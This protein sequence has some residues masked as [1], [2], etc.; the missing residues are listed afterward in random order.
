[1]FNDA[2]SY[3]GCTTKSDHRVVVARV[4]YGR[5]NLAYSKITKPYK[6]FDCA[7]LTSNTETQALYKIAVHDKLVEM[8]PVTNAN[9]EMNNMF[10]TIKG[11][12]EDTVGF[13][14]GSRVHNFYNDPLVVGL[15]DERKK[16]RLLLH[17]SNQSNDRSDLRKRINHFQTQIKRRLKE[18]NNN[19]AES[20]ANQINNTD[21]SRRMFE[22]V[23]SLAQVKKPKPIYVCDSDGNMVAN[24]IGKAKVL[25]DYFEDKFTSG[26]TT[27]LEC[28]DG[29]PRPLVVPVTPLEVENAAKCLK[30]GRAT[31]P[32]GIPS[33]FIKYS[34]PI[35]YSRYADCI[36]NSLSTNTKIDALGEGMINPLQ[37]PKKYLGPLKNIRPLTLSNSARK[38]LSMVT[39]RR[40][41]DKVN[42]YTGSC[43]SGYKVGRSCADI[44]WSQRML[45]AVVMRKEWQY[46]KLGIDMSSAFDTIKRDVVL[47]VLADAGCTEDELRLVRMLL[48]NTKLKINVNGTIS[49]EF[50]STIGA[51]QGDCLSGD[52]FTITLAAALHHLRA[53][54]SQVAVSPY[55]VTIP[56]P[57]PPISAQFM[58]LETEYADD[59]DFSNEK[60][61]PLDQLYPICKQVFSEWNLTVNDDKT[62]H[63]H[64]YLATPKPQNKKKMV[65]GVEYRG[66]EE[67]R[68]HKVLGS[69]L[70]S[71]EDI[72]KKCILGNAAYANFKKLWSRKEIS[73][74]RKLNIYEAQVVSIMLYNCNS[75][76]APAHVLEHLDVTH[77]NHLRDMLGI[78]WPR[79]YISNNQLYKRCDTRPL[80]ERVHSSRWKMLGHI[81]R[82]E[83]DAPALLALKFSVFAEENKHLFKGRLGAPCMNLLNVFRIDLKKRKI[84]N[85]LKS[86]S[87]LYNLRELAMDRKAWKRYII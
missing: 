17:S 70:C 69:I 48:S 62:E 63:F 3:S 25:K 32:D 86:I 36:N 44:V 20:L 74:N 39:L 76:A 66:H 78:K 46:F 61:E 21:S 42:V 2:R 68:N 67:W 71:V 29:P 49:L 31:G 52:L 10:D 6:R 33:E 5:I 30:N 41:R 28:F 85:N 18:L 54:L 87:D 60:K 47:N 19:A 8:P 79:G 59:V 81:L 38:V 73:I 84:N 75:W 24:D 11:C 27:P 51:F 43:Q 72:K 15:S 34:D 1:M 65:P 35:L 77:R 16:L 14:S 58:P 82:Y 83:D 12:A 56:I 55:L 22:A 37:K 23:R 50:E 57:N 13:K 64:F 26:D 7:N 45:L 40:I 9:Q 4:D 80:T 53:V